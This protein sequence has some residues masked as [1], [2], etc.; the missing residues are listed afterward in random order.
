[1]AMTAVSAVHRRSLLRKA[2]VLASEPG[3]PV[4]SILIQD[5]SVLTACI[6]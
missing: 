5:V 4:C 6:V 1:M 3:E 2:G